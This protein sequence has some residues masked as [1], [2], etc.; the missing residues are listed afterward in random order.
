[1]KIT[2]PPNRIKIYSKNPDEN[3][4]IKS[5]KKEEEILN[6]ENNLLEGGVS[7]GNTKAKFVLTKKDGTKL[8]DM[9]VYEASR[10]AGAAIKAYFAFSRKIKNLWTKKQIDP[11]SEYYNELK[12]LTFAPPALISL[13]KSTTMKVVHYLV[14]YEPNYTPNKH[15]I[16]KKI[17]KV[18]IVEKIS[19]LKLIENLKN[20]VYPEKY[21]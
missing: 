6:E 15:E 19:N 17:Y 20:V 1:M 16:N 11:N 2:V 13:R 9:Y 12:E 3:C 10:P 8:N 7:E 21:Y 4:S 14:H 18:P 5:F